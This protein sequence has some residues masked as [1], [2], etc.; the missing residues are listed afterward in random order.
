MPPRWLS[1]LIVAS[2]LGT[3][4]WLGYQHLAPLFVADQAPPYTIDLEDE[5]RQQGH[6][7][8]TVFYNDNPCLRAETWVEPDP[9]GDMFELHSEL[10][11]YV[12]VSPKAEGAASPF[13]GLV[14]IRKASSVYRVTRQGDLRAVRLDLSAVMGGAVPADGSLAGEVRNGRFT[15]RVAAS[16][17]VFPGAD[18]K[19]DLDPVA[20]PA[21]GSILSPMHPVN[22][23]TGLR[24]GQTWRLP[25]VDPVPTVI[26]ALARKYSAGLA[27]DAGGEAMVTAHVR[28]HTE[29]LPDADAA[30]CWVVDYQGGDVT[31]ATW[32]RASDGLVLRQEATRGGDRWVLQREQFT[33]ITR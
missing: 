31:A 27:P 25:L 1:I 10:H 6:I 7:R 9:A 16:S 28:P 22:R 12:G 20:V 29:P 32:V 23:I 30:P 21:H 8:W 33:L 24:P 13:G 11:P 15:G 3:T 4:G 2:W 18:F 17:P 5:V 26:A 19:S 14:E